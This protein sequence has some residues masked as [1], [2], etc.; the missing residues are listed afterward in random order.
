MT[1]A[2]ARRRTIERDLPP[3]WYPLRYHP[4]QSRLYHDRVRFKVVPAGRRSGKTELAKRKLVECGTDLEIDAPDAHFIAAAPV[5]H[6]AKRIFWKD[7]KALSPKWFVRKIRESELLI[8]YANGAD[9]RV[10]GM[11]KPERV[12]GDPIDGIVLDEYGN[13]KEKA[14]KENVRPALDTP[15]RIPGWAWLI[16]VPEGRN[17]YWKRA[18]YAQRRDIPNWAYYH[19]ISADIVDPDI[20]AEARTELDPLTYQQEFEGSFVNFQGR[21]YYAFDSSIHAVER[22]SYEPGAA[23]TFCFDFNVDPGV[24]AVAQE[25]MYRGVNPRVD[26]YFTAFIGEVWIPRNSNTLK[27]G[28]KLIAD[29]AHHKGDVLCYGDATG[30]AR[31]TAKVQGSD[32]E[33]LRNMFK[34][35][36]QSGRVKWNRV[37]F[38]VPRG[39]PKERARLNAVN[40]RILA[41]DGTIRLLVDPVK[42]SHLV[43]DFEG[44]V[45][46]EGGS[47]EIDKD[48]N[49]EL[50]H[51]SDG[52]GYYIAERWP[53]RERDSEAIQI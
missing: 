25:Q 47:G 49:D 19:W 21:A 6:Q 37:K 48:D 39:N 16:G 28:K 5:H 43:D 31:G 18:K 2:I 11:D 26:D 3:R 20:L 23:L 35:A 46:L 17:H 9:L 51:I 15:G 27:V 33:L 4:V 1:F 36:M 13:M 22:L 53:L 7:L 8:E 12:E 10:V 41:V 29:W 30:G 44:V 45:L 42:A 38:N 14:W 32:W 50:T 24:C 52:A 34:E 40:S